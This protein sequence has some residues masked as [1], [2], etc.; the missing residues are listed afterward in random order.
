MRAPPALVTVFAFAIACASCAL[1][2]LPA[3]ERCGPER[4]RTDGSCCPVHTRATLEG[5]VPRAFVELEPLGDG[6]ASSRLSLGVDGTSRAVV[7][8]VEAGQAV[9]ARDDGR[10][11][12]APRET[13]SSPSDGTVSMIDLSAGP[14]GEALVT[15]LTQGVPTPQHQV[16]RFAWRTSSSPWRTSDGPISFDAKAYEPRAAIG[17]EGDAMLVWTQWYDDAHFGVAVATARTVDA[18]FSFPVGASDVLSQPINFSNAPRVAV[19]SGGQAV[20]TWYQATEGELSTFVSE[21]ASRN[22]PMSHPSAGDYLS[23]PGAPIDSHPVSNP[24]V[25]LGPLGQA[26]VAW[27]QEDGRGHVDTYLATR[28][29]AGQWYRPRDLED[30]LSGHD[31]VARSAEL[32]FGAAGD[33][34]VVFEHDHELLMSVRDATGTW[35]TPRGLPRRL[36]AGSGLGLDPH[37]AAGTDGAVVVV[38]RTQNGDASELRVLRL[39]SGAVDLERHVEVAATGTNFT[40]P[41]VAIGGPDDRFVIGVVEHGLGVARL[42]LLSQ[43]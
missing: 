15:W 24:K 16:V 27:T 22:E 10:G 6:E 40:A 11:T 1:E 43:D 12:F 18:S 32:A 14:E 8:W 31:G 25:A 35:L 17:P 28:D 33:L 29:A 21:R 4:A 38:F 39:V 36:D 30:A 37:I 13:L 19:G 7:G 3:P 5:C 23:A 42:R 20:I 41:R 2:P 26:A 9:V 34:F